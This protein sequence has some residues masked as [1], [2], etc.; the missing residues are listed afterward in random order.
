MTADLD[1][2][3]LTSPF[4]LRILCE[5]SFAF[6][7]IPSRLGID[8][9]QNRTALTLVFEKLQDEVP[10]PK[11]DAWYSQ[12]FSNYDRKGSGLLDFEAFFD[13][14]QQYHSFHVSKRRSRKTPKKKP[15]DGMPLPSAAGKLIRVSCAAS[16]SPTVCSTVCSG[17]TVMF[18]RKTGRLAIFEHYE[19]LDRTGQGSFGKVLIVRHRQTKQIRACKAVGSSSPSELVQSEISFLKT[20]DHPNILRL[21]ETYEDGSNIYLVTELCEGGSLAD[22]I[23]YQYETVRVGISENLAA[24]Y[25]QQILSALAYCHSQGLIHRDVKPE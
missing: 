4:E 21:F 1:S 22:R 15:V 20:L 24:T 23:R 5:R 17:E 18:P 3:K 12:V 10:V 13:V 16:P 2:E 19:F 25:M 6:V 8:P 11:A 9:L 7:S 14:V